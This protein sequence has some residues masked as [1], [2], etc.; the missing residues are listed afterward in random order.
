MKIKKNIYNKTIDINNNLKHVYNGFNVSDNEYKEKRKSK[1][2]TND[3]AITGDFP[4][5][6]SSNIQSLFD[7]EFMIDGSYLILGDG[8]DYP[9]LNYYDGKFSYSSHTLVLDYENNDNLYMYYYW[10]KNINELDR[11]FQGSKLKNIKRS[12]FIKT[13]ILV[14]NIEN[15]K[16]IS[17]ILYKSSINIKKIKAL[18]EK[19]EIRNKYYADKLLSGDFRITSNS[20]NNIQEKDINDYVYPT[21]KISEICD[22]NTGKKD[23]NEGSEN[24]LYEFFTCSME[25]KKINNYSYDEEAI[26]I[27]GNGDPG[28]CKY[29]NG[30]FDAYQRVY[31][32]RNIQINA[33]YFYYVMKNY[34]KDSVQNLKMGGV[35][36]YIRLSD[37]LDF[38]FK[39]PNS[40]DIDLI[41]NSLNKLD[42]EK[43][44]VEK[45]LKLEEQRFEWLSDKL[46]S[47]E[48]IIED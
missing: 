21:I 5:F 26:L 1:K 3:G 40:N 12:L 4:F 24:G 14:P 32:L 34:F 43:L 46:L 16:K 18:L 13:K 6:T 33:K 37:I 7:K 25:N 28:V 39:C 23:A 27:T 2:L 42:D 19:M 10:L 47:G 35:I 29:F 44:K 8:G 17:K 38:E 11:C 30:K 45:L 48:Y 9:S 15:Q 31:I 41:L 20:I 22:I 36:Q